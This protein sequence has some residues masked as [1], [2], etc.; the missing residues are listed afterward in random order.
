MKYLLDDRIDDMNLDDALTQVSA[1]RREKVLLFKHESNRKESVAA[2]QLLCRLLHEEYGIDA[3]PSFEETITGKPILPDY[4]A[5]HFNL[6]H[7]R[8]VAACV[9]DQRPVGIDVERIR[10]YDEELARYVLDDA[11]YAE[12]QQSREKDVDFI[13]LWTMKESLLKLTGE[14]IRRDLKSVDLTD[15]KY[16]FTTKINRERGYVCTICESNVWRLPAE[17]EPQEAVQLA[18]PHDETDWLP[19][20]E[21][22]TVTYLQLTKAIAM[23]EKVVIVTPE[24]DVVQ[25]V[26]VRNL[27]SEVLPYITLVA[28]PTND[29]W[30]R[31][32]AAITLINGSERRMLDFRFNGWGEKFPAEFDNAVT[33]HVFDS[34]VYDVQYEDNLDFVLE[35]GSIECDGRGTILTTSHCLMAPH[36]N[37]PLSQ[38]QIE[39]ILKQRLHAER[40]LWL[41]YGNLV[42]DDTDGHIDTL[43]RFAAD[44]VIVYQG[45]Q[46]ADDAQY[47]DLLSMK[48]QLSEF[49]T[50][51]GKP[52]KLLELPMPRAL[53][54]EEGQRL[55]AT[56]ANFLVVNG[57]VI[58]PTY[59]D[60][61]ADK[62]AMS[63]LKEVFPDREIVPIDA[64]VIVRQHGSVHCITMQIPEKDNS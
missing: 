17:W 16:R 40:V 48:Q 56:Y 36:R 13:R 2:Y 33:H 59:A 26:L 57:V 50:A 19:C 32:H 4:P 18:W 29:T 51:D 20:L 37:Q 47:E 38:Q 21:E 6:S 39:T 64:R 54:D 3:Y 14:G 44:D 30:S 60:A 45:C 10:P 15:T 63:V 49:R 8:G 58:C 1:Q 12:L 46:Q 7:T 22:I 43:A 53:F 23:R 24:P 55:P 28:C 41:D 52:Y 62:T 42:G 27:P 31:D 5:I 9:V 25:D 11:E 34:G 35:G 61:E